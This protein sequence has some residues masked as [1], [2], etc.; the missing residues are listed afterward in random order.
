L[1]VV[2]LG[3]SSKTRVGEFAIAIGAPFELD[4]SVTFGHVSAKGR[5][6]IIPDPTLDQDFIQTDANINPG[7]SGGPLVNIEGE[8]IGINTL[9][10]GLRTGIGFAIPINMARD[11]A[12]QLIESGRFTR[13]WLGVGIRALRGDPDYLAMVKDLRE[14]VVVTEV[15]PNGPASQSDLK[16]T[17][18]IV[19]VDGVA[20]ETE[21]QL[22][23]EIR[24]K[25]LGT[26]VTLR[27]HRRGENLEVQVK[28]APWPDED[29]L[30]ARPAKLEV[31]NPPNTMGLTVRPAN[32]DLAKEFGVDSFDGLIVTE[33]E[34]GSPASQKG[35]RAGD[36]ITDVD[37]ESVRTIKEFKEAM[38][39][40][41]PG[42]GI[43]LNFVSRGTS[44]FEILKE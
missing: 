2:R 10:R 4:Y 30:A 13:A 27:V 8:V 16:P 29:I 36:I 5:S 14:G 39:K 12:E 9:I 37:R 22:K 3:D 19:A 18:V 20:V 28:P 40:G 33:V 15:L 41:D 21:Q 1:E 44:K 38:G 11:V 24:S 25:R 43:I 17:D 34:A 31:E 7:N 23:N 35:I 42:R 32:K 6:Y 26:P